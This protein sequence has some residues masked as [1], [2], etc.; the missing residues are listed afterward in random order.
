MPNKIQIAKWERRRTSQRQ[1]GV[2]VSSN[3]PKISSNGQSKYDP[4]SLEASPNKR[5]KTYISDTPSWWRINNKW[6]LVRNDQNPTYTGPNWAK[7]F[8]SFFYVSDK[9]IFEPGNKK[10]T[11]KAENKKKKIYIIITA[12]GLISVF[13][14]LGLIVYTNSIPCKK[15]NGIASFIINAISVLS[16][17]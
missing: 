17:R 9:G 5:V 16:K 12:V 4:A 15:L 2:Y 1:R 3:N 6:F 7:Y 13:L 11:L 14:G 10:E 8:Y